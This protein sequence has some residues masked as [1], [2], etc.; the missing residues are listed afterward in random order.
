MSAKEAI[1]V[2]QT[3]SPRVPQPP[4]QRAEAASPT[5]RL[6][7]RLRLGRLDSGRGCRRA[8]ARVAHWMVEGKIDSQVGA[9]VAFVIGKVV[10]ALELERAEDL[11]RAIEQLEALPGVAYTALPEPPHAVLV[12]EPMPVVDHEERAP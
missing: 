12:R 6:M 7:P 10:E 3:R 5:P 11:Q 1:V 8:V 2:G 9:R 4:E